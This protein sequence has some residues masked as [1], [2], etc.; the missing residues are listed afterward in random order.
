MDK[1]TS[2][3][4]AGEVS[5]GKTA[6]VEIFGAALKAVDPYVCVKAHAGSVKS[7][8][9][10]GNFRRMLL[11]GFGKAAYPMAHALTDYAGGMVDSG[12]MIT[13]YGHAPSVSLPHHVEVREAGHPIPDENG[14]RATQEVIR[15]LCG[16]DPHTLTVCLISGGGSALLVA[17]YGAISLS[18]KQEVT[19]LLLARGA[20]INEVNAVRKHISSVKGGRLGAAMFPGRA[21]SLILSDVIGD[22]LDV[23]ASG[24]TAPDKTTYHDAYRVITRY[25]MVG[26]TAESILHVLREGMEGRIPE[27]PKPGDPVFGGIENLI[28]GNNGMATE[29]ARLKAEHLGFAATVTSVGRCC[30][31]AQ[32]SKRNGATSPF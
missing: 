14:Y 1:Q 9:E 25:G 3:P 13:K 7:V 32:I 29:A 6:A 5:E 19:R 31:A 16:S 26:E 18:E 28:I 23:I 30:V 27:T 11:I 12:I 15:L 4:K 17:P 10:S 24:P 2:N 20:D 8:F 21:V 22:K